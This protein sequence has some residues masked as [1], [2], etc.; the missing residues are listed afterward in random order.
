MRG[1]QY[2]DKK[3]WIKF[4]TAQ[5]EDLQAGKEMEPPWIVWP[6]SRTW[7][8][9][10]GNQEGWMHAVFIPFWKRMSREERITYVAKWNPPEHWKSTLLG[11]YWLRMGLEEY[12][13]YDE[14]G[15]YWLRL[16]WEKWFQSQLDA[17]SAGAEMEPP[18]I[19][20]PEREP[21]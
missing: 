10:Q 7:S 5:L 11:E 6:G 2:L 16:E 9:K 12:P 13:D 1:A 18:W 3:E 17:L 14:D 4:F 20:W 21:L 19:T 8:F 15:L